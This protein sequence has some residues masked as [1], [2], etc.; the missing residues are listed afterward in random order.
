MGVDSLSSFCGDRATQACRVCAGG[1]GVTTVSAGE[2]PYRTIWILCESCGSW[3]IGHEPDKKRLDAFYSDYSGHL[4][5]SSINPDANDGRR[6]TDAWRATRER[7]YRL[8][9]RDI[10]LVLNKSDH[11]VDFGGYDGVFLDVC[12]DIQP[13]LGRS[14]AVD[15]PRDETKHLVALG[16]CFEAIDD[17]LAGDELVD[18]VSLW[19]VYEHISDL[20]TLMKTLSRRVKAGGQVIVQ[21]PR[22]HLHARLL[23]ERW[24]H[25]LPVQHLQLPSREGILQQFDA[26]G[27]TASQ[28][29][30]FGANA[31]GSLIPQPYKELFDGLAKEADLGS[32]QLIRFARR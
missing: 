10:G 18:I 28:V 4:K 5:L 3:S 21:T 6:Y 1:L 2:G 22:A 30:S 27:F 24:H 32:T 20:P 14:T 19:D 31:P 13:D 11:L 17:W 8:G 23:G 25:F 9:I 29:G 26:Y 16:H 15:Y 7:E 12:R